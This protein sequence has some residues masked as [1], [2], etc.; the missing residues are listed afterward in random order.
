VFERVA[1]GVVG[2]AY[3]GIIGRREVKICGRWVNLII[4]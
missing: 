4:P 1:E 2:R 3:E